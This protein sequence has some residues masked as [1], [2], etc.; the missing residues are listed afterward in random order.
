MLTF[1]NQQKY[2][3]YYHKDESMDDGLSMDDR[4]ENLI[5][6]QIHPYFGQV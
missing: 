1:E 5:F 4:T 6:G 2:N 3:K